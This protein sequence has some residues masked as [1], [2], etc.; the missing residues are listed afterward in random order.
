MAD[1]GGDDRGVLGVAAARILEL[2]PHGGGRGRIDHDLGAVVPIGSGE[3]AGQDVRVMG[4]ESRVG[5]DAPESV[6]EDARLGFAEVRV[7]ERLPDKYAGMHCGVV[8]E[9]HVGRAGSDD[10]LGYWG[11]ERSASPDRDATARER[12]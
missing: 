12:L 8:V 4:G 9:D 1:D 5:E 7:H 6:S 10:R 11:A 3:W 2:C